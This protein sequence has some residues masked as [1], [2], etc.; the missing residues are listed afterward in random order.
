[1]TEPERPTSTR[2]AST[3]GRV[4]TL[5]L[6]LMACAAALVVA[7]GVFFRSRATIEEI[8]SLGQGLDLLRLERDVGFAAGTAEL[9]ALWLLY[10][11]SGESEYRTA[12]E[13][14]EKE[15]DRSSQVLASL[16]ATDAWQPVVQRLAG[17]ATEASDYLA[18]P[19]TPSEV[20]GWMEDFPERFSGIFPSDPRGRW[21]ALL[22]TVQGAQYA[23]YSGFGYGEL[24]L[25][26]H[27]FLQGITPTD[28]SLVP[29]LTANAGNLE[30][31]G[32]TRPEGFSPFE[33]DLDIARAVSADAQIG[34]LVQSLRT[35]PRVRR[36]EGDIDYLVGRSRV[37]WFSNEQQL[38]LFTLDLAA[39]LDESAEEVLSRAENLLAV[40]RVRAIRDSR[41]ALAAAIMA[42][43]LGA[44]LLSLLWR[45]R[46][47]E[48]AHLR[49][50]AE[51]DALTGIC[52]RF[53]LFAREQTR[54]RNPEAAP[55]ALV[56]MDLDHF[57]EIN[58]RYGHAVGDAALVE[59]AKVCR[60]VVRA[61]SD[62]VARIGG[63]EFVIVLHGLADPHQ[64]A[65]TVVDR[66]HALLET[67]MDLLGH[68]LSIKT[69]AGIAVATEPVEL[70]NLLH[71][72]DVAL[73]EAKKAHPS[74]RTIFQRNLHGNLIHEIEDA[75]REGRVQPVFQPI[76]RATNH[77][78]AGFEVLAR[79]VRED[80][81]QVPSESLV[82]V[83]Q[84]LGITSRWLRIIL[85]RIAE[86]EP[87]LGDDLKGRFW[88]NVS[89]ADLVARGDE[90]IPALFQASGI[91]L[92][93]LGVEVTERVCR[94]DL[95]AVRE[96]LRELRALG[97]QVALDDL[98][99]DGVP[100]RH[101]LDLPLDRVK[102]D[103]GL[104][105]GLERSENVRHI[106]QGLFAIAVHLKLQI[107]AEQ[108][109][110]PEEQRALVQLGV[111]Y[112]QGNLIR[113]AVPADEVV[114]IVRS[115]H[116]SPVH[117]VA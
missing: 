73:L 56:H 30:Q 64:E 89:L 33:E 97:V 66:I 82:R 48:E 7:G 98:G 74:R 115:G 10:D 111:T 94:A 54:L 99:S 6:T 26:R 83:L 1:M 77:Q 43:G 80:G 49:S 37:P 55:F 78:T 38:L 28:A 17:L 2:S 63:D 29:V 104:I 18:G 47:R 5:S 31:L 60:S 8:E 70:E 41:G 100:L 34:V 20:R 85:A 57:K 53:A 117:G 65:E 112:L 14:F 45:G 25:S 61:S 3:I 69:S 58:D 52:N 42:F 11:G 21:S 27:A 107:V 9:R 81:T 101:L 93:R 24:A 102:L 88:I 39:E 114:A 84:S 36:V 68:R 95:V 46:Q 67:P 40:A 105:R 51:T 15:M 106:V 86:I 19:R 87:Q 71:Q 91:P 109:E 44:V 92:Q 72:A 4:W 35:G 75:L 116:P 13:R 79:W 90:A 22:G 103:G 12:V 62:T 108:I 110:T 113:G 16:P 76:V 59:F 32:V 50:V 96:T 23:I